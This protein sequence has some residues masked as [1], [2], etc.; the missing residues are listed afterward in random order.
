MQ[1]VEAVAA[2]VVMRLTA[3]GAHEAEHAVAESDEAELIALLLGRQPEDERGGDEALE[4]RRPRARDWKLARCQP[5][6]I[7][8]NVDLLRS[9]DLK[10]FRHRMSAFGRRLPVDLVVTVARHV[11]A[12]LL[13]IAPLASLALGV[14]ADC[15]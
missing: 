14:K 13:K 7:D 15:A 4:R 8:D 1:R 12:E 11:L 10:H 5:R 2:G 3:F 9:L 6:G